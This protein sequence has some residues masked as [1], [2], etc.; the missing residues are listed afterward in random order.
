[1]KCLITGVE[2]QLGFDI[3]NELKRRTGY[4]YY[5]PSCLEMDITNRDETFKKIIEY[6][7]DVIFHCAA[8]TAVDKAE[9]NKND[10]FSVN[11]LGTKN[12]VDAGKL[13]NSK[14]VYISTDYVFDGTKDGEYFPDDTRNPINYYGYTKMCGEEYVKKL[15]DYLIVRISWV[16]GINGNNFIKTMLRLA[17]E[18]KELSI[19]SDQIGSPTYTVDLAK[20]LVD[21]VE[22]NKH[23]VF[24]AT[25]EGNCSWSEFAKYIFDITNNDVIID[26]ILT[27]D[28][29]TLAKRPINSRLNKDKLDFE[30][31]DRLPSWQ[32]ATKRFCRCLKED[33]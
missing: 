15:E 27:K 26:E 17:K 24:H 20:L 19:V 9:E 3:V 11:A 18:K 1:M 5:A 10:C 29:K 32:D 14:V 22:K 4:D 23:G 12:I 30:E 33:K 28:Y 8:Y 13:C 21:M 6:K 2:G 25:N 31:L 7:P 16:F